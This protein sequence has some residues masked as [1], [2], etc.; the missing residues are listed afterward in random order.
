MSKKK[1]VRFLLDSVFKKEPIQEIMSTTC[2]VK[3]DLRR[4]EEDGLIICLSC[5]ICTPYLIDVP[6]DIYENRHT[7]VL[8]YAYKRINHFKELL[9]QAQAKQSTTIPAIVIDTLRAEIEK[10]NI[11]LSEWSLIDTRAL[12][13]KLN[14]NK[15]YE[16]CS[17]IRAKLGILPPYMTLELETTLCNLFQLIQAPFYK[18]APASR[19]NFLNYYYVMYKLCEMLGETSYLPHFPMLK[20]RTK[21]K[22]QDDIW[23]LICGELNWTYI[24]SAKI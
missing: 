8:V 4:A 21:I 12:L 5:G 2:C 13:K 19:V 20:E 3:P 14:F 16:H 22:A 9:A 1:K 24:S 6:D 17:L 15:Y 11:I 18:H 7:E 23:R 10:D